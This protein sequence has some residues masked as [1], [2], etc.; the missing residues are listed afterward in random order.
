LW[1]RPPAAIIGAFGKIR[2]GTPLPHAALNAATFA[3]ITFILLS[4][5]KW[6]IRPI[7]ALREK[8]NPWN[9]TT[10][11]R[12]NFSRALIATKFARAPIGARPFLDGH[13][14]MPCSTPK[15]FPVLSFELLTPKLHKKDGK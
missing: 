13:Y 15:N 3:G 5:Q 7:S 6:P 14:Q 11:L 10:C 12:L 2:G 1:Q 8:S 4:I 9:I